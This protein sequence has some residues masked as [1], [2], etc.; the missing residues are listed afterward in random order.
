M[1][2]KSKLIKKDEVNIIQG[3]SI[4]SQ[5]EVNSLEQMFEKDEDNEKVNLSQLKE[6]LNEKRGEDSP[7][8]SLK[9][10]NPPQKSTIML[11][12]DIITG[13]TTINT[14]NKDEEENGFKYIPGENKSNEPKYIKYEGA[15]IESIIPKREFETMTMKNPLDKREVRFEGSMQSRT[16]EQTS[17]EKYSPVGRIDKEKKITKNPFDVK[18]IKYTPEKY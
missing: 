12:R 1:P 11:E 9:K 3:K 17:F 16:P 13:N 8:P 10:I 7:S 5:E 15:M 6:F 14:A 18:E 4:L 2:R